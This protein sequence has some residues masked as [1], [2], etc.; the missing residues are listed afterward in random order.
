[1][2]CQING[3]SY[4]RGAYSNGNFLQYGTVKL[5]QITPVI[6]DKPRSMSV[7]LYEG[8]SLWSYKF[9]NA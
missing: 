5:V 7:E 3:S 6:V 8:V 4:K 2:L 1:M 9:S